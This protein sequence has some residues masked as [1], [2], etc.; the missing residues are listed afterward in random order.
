MKEEKKYI[1]KLF[2]GSFPIDEKEAVDALHPFVVILRDANKIVFKNEKSL[3]IEEKILVYGLVKKL[4][5]MKNLGES[6]A[7]SAIEINKSLRIKKGSVDSIFNR[8]RKKNLI[9][10]RGKN[11]TLC[12]PNEI[13][14]RLKE[15]SENEKKSKDI[16]KIRRN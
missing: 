1:E 2:A 3:T 9:V 15:K 16:N 14:K 4:L 7:F 5:K 13:I 11:Y 6:E 10:G 12:Q 8:L